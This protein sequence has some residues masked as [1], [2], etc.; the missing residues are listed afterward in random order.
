MRVMN[1]QVRLVS[2]S[3]FAYSALGASIAGV[4]WMPATCFTRDAK[5]HATTPPPQATPSTVSVAFAP[6][7]S[8]ISF[9]ATAS[10]IGLAVENGVA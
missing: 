6:D 10:V 8:T 9:S 1:Y 2:P 4:M 3:S 7:V 5:A